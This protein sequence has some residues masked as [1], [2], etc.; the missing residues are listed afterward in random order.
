MSNQSN[1]AYAE[2]S[3]NHF[4]SPLDTIDE[5]RRNLLDTANKSTQTDEPTV[6][7]TVLNEENSCF[8]SKNQ[9]LIALNHI[10]ELKKEISK[11]R[12]ELSYMYNKLRR[13]TAKIQDI[14][15]QA[16]SR[17]CYLDI[18]N[19]TNRQ[20]RELITFVSRK[21]AQL[22]QDYEHYKISNDH[23]DVYNKVSALLHAP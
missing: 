18:A 13:E 14:A 12:G 9:L 10:E 6:P 23:T 3:G 15:K 7:T 8:E 11:Y 4:S 5:C 21:Y 1:K 17:Q 16:S 20:Q 2:N 19:Y 22:A